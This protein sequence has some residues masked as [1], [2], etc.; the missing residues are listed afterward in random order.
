[1]GFLRSWQVLVWMC[2]V[3][4]NEVWNFNNALLIEERKIQNSL[5]F[6]K[7]VKK[8]NSL[9]LKEK[10]KLSEFKILLH[11]STFRQK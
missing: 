4:L 9:V 5:K 11:F 1:M 3:V 2:K 6:F 7:L 10:Q 8:K